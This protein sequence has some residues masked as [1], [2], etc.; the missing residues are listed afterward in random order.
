MCALNDVGHQL[1]NVNDLDL[2]ALALVLTLEQRVGDE[3]PLELAVVDVLQRLA[4]EQAVC[5]AAVD[6]RSTIVLEHLCRHAQR[7]TGVE[8]IVDH[9][10]HLALHIA[11]QV[12][13]LDHSGSGALLDNERQTTRT[14]SLLE[15]LGSRHATAIG[16]NDRHILH[17]QA[18]LLHLPTH[19]LDKLN[20]AKDVV[21][22]SRRHALQLAAMQVHRDDAR[23]TRCLQQIHD[24]RCCD[25]HT[26]FGLAI[27]SCI[28]EQWNHCRNLG[29]TITTNK[30]DKQVR[31][32]STT[33][34]YDKQARQ[35]STTN[36]HD[37]QAR[38]QGI[39]L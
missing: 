12:H 8:Q 32:T 1:R 3:Q 9:E 13:L 5:D 37:K 24:Q 7:A 27:L 11:D 38:Q 33:N 30:Y 22:R 31:Q 36:K 23:H 34:K 17:R 2:G 21:D 19:A 28:R 14:R 25:R 4:T 6:V 16:C 39:C 10:A 26:A 15:L 18:Q 20:V 35:T 29:S